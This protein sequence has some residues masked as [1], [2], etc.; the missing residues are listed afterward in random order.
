M[1]ALEDSAALTVGHDRR[2]GSLDD[3]RYLR[4]SVRLNPDLKREE[5]KLQQDG[6]KL[7]SSEI[8]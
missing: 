1:S 4:Q 5:P 2:Q 7:R 6:R 3:V 8:P